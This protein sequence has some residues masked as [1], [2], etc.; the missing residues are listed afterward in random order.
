MGDLRRMGDSLEIR[1]LG[2]FEVAAGGRRVE[3]PGSK[4]Q[5][6]LAMLAL[7]NG[8]VGAVDDLVDALWGADLPAAP[9]NAVQHHVARLRATLGHEAL[10]A[11]GDGYALQ[12]AAVDAVSFEELLAAAASARR[13]GDPRAAAADAAAALALWRGAA[14]QGLTDAPWFA[15]EA[16]R[17]DGL[18]LDVQEERF[19]AALALG[20]HREIAPELRAALEEHPYRERLWGQLMVALYRSGRQADALETYH[21]ARRVL[22]DGLGLEP[23]PELRSLQEAI[24]AHDPAIAALPVVPA[25]RGN[26]PAPATSFVGREAELGRVAALLAEHRV[27]TLLGPPG[28]G[29]TRIALEA[30]RPLRHD[31]KG[32]VWFVDLARAVQ[33]SDITRLVARAVEARGGDQL[34]RVVERLRDADAIL[35]FDSCEHLLGEVR[36]VID[37]VLAGCP[38]VRVLATSREVL[39]VSGEARLT[40][41]PLP[42][43]GPEAAGDRDSPAVNL[44]AQRARAARPGFELDDDTT[45]LA[46]EIV[47]RVDGLPLG[48]ELAAA[49]VSL[50]GLPEL[51]AL[52]DRRLALVD[53]PS[54]HAG[55]A[56][57]TLVE[58][59]YDLLHADE[60]TLVQQIGVHGGGSSLASLVAV[61]GSH[62]LDEASVAHLLEGLVDKS[63]IMVSFPDG[64]ARYSLLDTVRDYALDRLAQAG[65]LGAARSSHAA[66]FAAFAER[67]RGELRGSG[68]LE[69]MRRVELE[70]DN[71]WAALRWATEA[72]EPDTAVRLAAALGWYFALAERVSEGRRF[73]AQA[74]EYAGDGVPVELRVE[75]LAMLCYLA[76]EESDLQS[77]LVAGEEAVALG[78][79]ADVSVVLTLAQTAL[80][81]AADRSGDPVRAASLA[82]AAR[83]RAVAAGDDWGAAAASLVRAFTAAATADVDTV[84]AMAA[85]VL[86]HEHAIGY[87]PFEVPGT[88]LQGWVATHRDDRPVAEQAYH[89]T[90]ELADATGFADHA[91]FAFALLGSAAHAAGDLRRADLFLRQALA[92]AQAAR[93]SWVMAHARVELGHAL[94]EGGDEASAERLYRAVMDWSSIPRPHGARET[95]FIALAG[96]PAPRALLGLADLAERR[97]DALGASDLRQRAQLATT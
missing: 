63:I 92:A 76:T 93:A 23:G 5:A 19:D 52:V 72:P 33:P 21:E 97:G 74:L 81:L 18:R 48:I 85:E 46:G 2:P 58:W 47:R 37:S 59:S 28:V 65:G 45:K 61:G 96:D 39:H 87:A 41:E 89:R 62:E 91:A 66:F 82:D 14:L 36:R 57:R 54:S 53:E 73:I 13:A 3:I 15:S 16:R 8:R 4:R 31:V 86:R 34:D 7:R 1:L 95:L 20:E 94:A 78:A 17:L 69:S 79:D 75:G 83:T 67:E 56:L 43:P 64:G 25:R 35:V 12:H 27:V 77:A 38:G 32:G 55:A 24:L 49:R 70:N 90:L 6:L 80:A 29:K 60:K 71:F 10:A 84:A 68:W 44:F 26:L 22:S 9:R 50:L 11:S 40:V 42:L 88:L 51:L 30:V